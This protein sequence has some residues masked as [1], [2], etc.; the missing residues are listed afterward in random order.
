MKIRRIF[1]IVVAVGV[2]VLPAAAGASTG[3]VIQPSPSPGVNNYNTLRSVSCT[4]TSACTAV[5]YYTNDHTGVTI[6]E[7]WNG[8]SWKV[9]PTPNP[10]GA[11]V[12][13]LFGVKCVSATTV[14]APRLGTTNQ[15]RATG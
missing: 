11:I 10:T 5:G 13:Y 8:T 12:S 3:W 7:R 6:A 4:A 2:A 9:Q 15:A 1:A 14:T